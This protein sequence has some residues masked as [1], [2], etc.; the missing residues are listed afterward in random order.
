MLVIINLDKENMYLDICFHNNMIVL[1][2][3]KLKIILNLSPSP[4]PYCVFIFVCNC[5]SF[6]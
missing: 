5:V 2:D 4:V 1:K 3:G 6:R